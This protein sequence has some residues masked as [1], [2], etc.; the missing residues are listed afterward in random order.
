VLARH[1]Q[2]VAASADAD[3]IFDFV[4]EVAGIGALGRG[5][6]FQTRAPLATPYAL[7]AGVPDEDA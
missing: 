5:F 3:E 7:P 1:V 6:V 4:S 2:V